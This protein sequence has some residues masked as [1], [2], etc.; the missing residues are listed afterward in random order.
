MATGTQTPWTRHT[1]PPTP[2]TRSVALSSFPDFVGLQYRVFCPSF[3]AVF[4]KS[5]YFPGHYRNLPRSRA[6]WLLHPAGQA[7][8]QV[9]LPQR[10]AAPGPSPAQDPAPLWVFPGRRQAPEHGSPGH[11]APPPARGVLQVRLRE[12][13]SDAWPRLPRGRH[14]RGGPGEQHLELCVHI[15]LME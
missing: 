2:T 12:G 13:V 11:P 14:I 7:R 6:E 15:I 9:L 3:V 5:L 8:K 1:S 4:F 10:P